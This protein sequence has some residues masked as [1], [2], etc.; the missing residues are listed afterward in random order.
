MLSKEDNALIS[1]VGRGTPMGELMR[2]YWVPAVLSSEL[3]QADADPLRVMLLGEKLIAFRDTSGRVGLIQHNCP[4]RGASLFFGRNEESGLRCVYHGWKFAVDGACVDMPNEPAESD[5]RTRVRAT[6][7]PTIERNGIVWAYLGP[8]SVP[9]PLPHLEGNMLADGE[10]TITAIQRECN[11]LQALEGDID[12]SHFSFLHAGSLQATS[13][14]RGTFSY[15]MLTDRAPR[16]AVVDTSYGAMYG[17]YRDTD[18]GRRYWRVAQYLFP[19]Y[20]MPPQ[21]VLGHKITVRCWVPMDDEHTL[22]I[23]SGPRPRRPPSASGSPL[24]RLS[25]NTSDWF[26]RFRMLANASNDYQIDRQKQRRNANAED[27]T[28]ITGIHLQDQ[29]ITES[30]GSVYD[31]SLEHLGSSDTM[32]IRVRRRLLAAAAALAEQGAVPPGVDSPEDY[33]VRAGGVFL[34]QS[35]DWLEAT[36]RLRQGFVSH[37]DL[38]LAVTGPLV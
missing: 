7:Y 14:Q 17:A 13:Q 38:D 15:Y 10:W 19:F 27:F 18:D 32:V 33:A 23:M 16:Y 30:M 31:R 28:G 4:H 2:Q 8:R 25:P 22:F 36:E 37:P 1:Q 9:P 12:T 5:F 26:G 35:Q 20:T 6:A 3:P 21:G 34:P 29:A 11:W 24:G